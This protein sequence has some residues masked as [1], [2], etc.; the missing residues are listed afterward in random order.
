MENKETE[1]Q[2]V[3]WSNS[4]DSFVET[5]T[6]ILVV[7]IGTIIYKY[8][9]PYKV[10]SVTKNDSHYLIECEPAKNHKW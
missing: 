3:F 9:Y 5:W 2:Y 10:I 8:D 7:E 4:G 1:H 6:D